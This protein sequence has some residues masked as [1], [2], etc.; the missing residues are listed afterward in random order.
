MH[1]PSML[2][3][4]VEQSGPVMWVWDINIARKLL[5]SNHPLPHFVLYIFYLV[6]YPFKIIWKLLPGE[7][8]PLFFF[9]SPSHNAIKFT[10]DLVRINGKYRL[11]GKAGFGS[12]SKSMTAA[13]LLFDSIKLPRWDLPCAQ[14]FIGTRCCHQTGACWGKDSSLGAQVLH[15]PETW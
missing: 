10:M 2:H 7:Y 1:V 13:P 6:A 5:A 14:H 4:Y 12:Y 9:I 15:V 3:H 11:G 8:R